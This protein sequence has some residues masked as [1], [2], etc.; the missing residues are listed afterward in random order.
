MKSVE[1]AFCGDGNKKKTLVYRSSFNWFRVKPLA[2][3]WKNMKFDR[4]SFISSYRC[5][6]RRLRLA[7]G[8]IYVR[9][10]AR[11]RIRK[12]MTKRDTKG[13]LK[14]TP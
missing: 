5:V 3:I 14:M 7:G 6:L 11:A 9:L 1:Q 4:I 13:A 10:H 2:V 12:K 8:K